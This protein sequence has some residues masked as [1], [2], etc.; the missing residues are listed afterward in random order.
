MR[1]VILGSRGLLGKALQAAFRDHTVFAWDKDELDITD[2]AAVLKQ[3][4]VARADVV[5]NA[6]AYN[7]VDEAERSADGALLA[8]RLNSQAVG[9]VAAAARAVEAKLVHFSTDYVFDGTT[10]RAYAEDDSPNPL[11][12]YGRSKRQGEELLLKEAARG[13]SCYLVRTSRLFGSSGVGGKESFL[14]LVLR[15]AQDKK[16]L[17]FIDG[18]EI[19]SPTYVL[20][21]AEAVHAMVLDKCPFGIYHRTNSGEASWYQLAQAVL[22]RSRQFT[23]DSAITT[24][25]KTYVAL[26]P[27]L[28]GEVVRSAPRPKYSVLATTKLPPLRPWE[29]ALGEYMGEQERAMLVE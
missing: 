29:E 5:L 28:A 15:L 1:V 17:A 4:T 11:S 25:K 9:A 26:R 16:E 23:L 3:L 27:A 18:T 8:Q 6:A 12:V 22:M 2:S 13:L 19:S 21:L 24:E 20:D 10:G 14:D 7:A